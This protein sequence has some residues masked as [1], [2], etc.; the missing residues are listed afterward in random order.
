MGPTALV[1]QSR[2]SN[3]LWSRLRTPQ[4]ALI[5]AVVALGIWDLA[6]SADAATLSR[7]AS[8]PVESS[9]AIAGDGWALRADTAPERWVEVMEAT[10]MY[11][12]GGIRMGVAEV[13]D[14]YRIVFQEEGWLLVVR[15]LEPAS[16]P[17]WLAHD[18]RVSITFEEGLSYPGDDLA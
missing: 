10:P 17:V 9:L 11:S 4:L 14:R 1:N 5:L 6:V 16:A 18:A 12:E 3:G 8:G 7:P 13:G 2:F 15:G